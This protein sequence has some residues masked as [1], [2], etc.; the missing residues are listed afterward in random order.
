[1]KIITT[2]NLEEY[3]PIGHCIVLIEFSEKE[4][5]N[6][7]LKVGENV[8]RL[9]KAK[10]IS[11]MQLALAIG[12]NSVG[13]VAKAELYKYDKHFSLEQLYKISRILKVSLHELLPE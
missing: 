6:F 3:L 2:I 7:Y 4:I 5:E 13:H 11:Q 8:K 9:R 10:N 1:M 12:H